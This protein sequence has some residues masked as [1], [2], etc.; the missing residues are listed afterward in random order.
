MSSKV[1]LLLKKATTF[2]R[3]ALYGDRKSFLQAIAQPLPDVVVPN[4]PNAP[5]GQGGVH[6][7]NPNPPPPAPTPLPPAPLPRMVEPAP[8][9]GGQWFDPNV[10]LNQPP[11]ID[12]D[13]NILLQKQLNAPAVR[14]QAAPAAKPS[15]PYAT[16]LVNTLNAFS[17]RAAGMNDAQK[18]ATLR[19][20]NNTTLAELSRILQGL[21]GYDNPYA[22]PQEQ[23][24]AQQIRAAVGNF[25]KAFSSQI[26][27][28]PNYTRL[29]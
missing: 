11:A 24:L 28:A 4:D 27:N 20:L 22:T 10:R 3:L 5:P 13:P 12:R 29:A 17:G 6:R 1:D 14:E 25:G 16:Q 19:Q 21:G 23:A 2:E 15:V 9:G 7:V 26:T 8:G 18:A